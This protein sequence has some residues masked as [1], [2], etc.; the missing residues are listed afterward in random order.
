MFLTYYLVTTTATA[1]A[2]ATVV[3]IAYLLSHLLVSRSA[4]WTS[5]I[6]INPSSSSP[7][8]LKHKHGQG[9]L[10]E[11]KYQVIDRLVP[12]PSPTRC[13][14]ADLVEFLPA[15][16]FRCSFRI[17]R[18]PGPKERFSST[19]CLAVY[20]FSVTV[21]LNPGSNRVYRLNFGLS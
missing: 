16:F 21:N 15:A 7:Q 8:L 1:T 5:N 9:S 3:D 12:S 20:L 18:P 19:V 2:T 13:F 11:V 6:V 14:P 4:L 17:S 10:T